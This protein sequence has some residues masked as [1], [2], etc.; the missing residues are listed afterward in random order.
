MK[1]GS[2][3]VETPQT[4]T[5]LKPPLRVNNTHNK[6]TVGEEVALIHD[7]ERIM[8][9]EITSDEE[10]ETAEKMERKLVTV[11]LVKSVVESGAKGD[12]GGTRYGLRK[13]R[14]PAGD[15]LKRLEHNQA[16]NSGGLARVGVGNRSRSNSK[17]SAPPPSISPNSTVPNPLAVAAAATPIHPPPILPKPLSAAAPDPAPSMAPAV[18]C[19]LPASAVSNPTEKPAAPA[20]ETEASAAP[21]LPDKRKV[22]INEPPSRMR[23]FS[24]DLESVGLDFPE[25]GTTNPELALPGSGR[26]RGFSFEFFAFGLNPDEPPLP[27]LGVEDAPP[28][29]GRPRLDSLVLEPP[30][31]GRPRGDS[32]IFDPSSFQEGGIHEQSALE[33]GRA[34]GSDIPGLALRHAGAPKPEAATSCPPSTATSTKPPAPK[35]ARTVAPPPVQNKGAPVAVASMARSAAAPATLAAPAVAIKPAPTMS[36][37]ASILPATTPDAPPSSSPPPTLPAVTSY[38]A[39]T[40]TTTNSSTTTTVTVTAST[41]TATLPMDKLNKDGRIGI[42]FPDARKARI[43]RFHAKRARR[44]WRKRIKYDCRKKLADSRPRIKGRFVKR[45]DMGEEE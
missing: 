42:Y 33:K 16:T 19:P 26:A 41:N 37:P 6:D 3:I 1:P 36:A 45:S 7:E 21:D 5:G 9:E 29:A 40:T 2:S 15:D 38:T 43:A 28:A 39:T 32:I 44:I 20:E 30:T 11:A 10:S 14:R 24:I 27:P 12:D 4:A 17:V 22:T 23:G 8:D 35:R 13:R 25:E 34:P 31:S 18:P